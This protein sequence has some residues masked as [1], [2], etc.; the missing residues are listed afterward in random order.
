LL[1]LLVLVTV[2]PA[3]GPALPVVADSGGWSATGPST[4]V[5]VVAVDPGNSS[6]VYAGGSSGLWKSA[7]GGGTWQQVGAT[8]LGHFLAIDPFAP[9]VLYAGGL[10]SHAYGN[11]TET[12]TSEDRLLK[13]ADGGATWNVVYQVTGPPAGQQSVIKDVLLDPNRQGAVFLAL[14][15]NDPCCAQVASSLDGGKSWALILPLNIGEMSYNTTPGQQSERASR[16]ARS[17]RCRHYQLPRWKHHADIR[18]LCSGHASLVRK[19]G[20]LPSRSPA[21]RCWPWLGMLR[22]TRSTASGR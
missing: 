4:G 14:A 15:G 13:S 19:W 2:L 3:F 11:G 16:R 17:P 6:L 18:R 20:R 22:T 7:D 5:Q 8:A 10:T 21:R 9:N 12:Y 1:W